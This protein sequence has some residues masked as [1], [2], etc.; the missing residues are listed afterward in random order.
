MVIGKQ[1]RVSGQQQG[2]FGIKRM[3]EDAML[4]EALVSSSLHILVLEDHFNKS[5]ICFFF[6]GLPYFFESLL[7]FEAIVHRKKFTGFHTLP[8]PQIRQRGQLTLVYKH[9][10]Q[11][12][13][14]IFDLFAK[15]IE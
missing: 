12:L 5:Q 4:E 2:A 3:L 6:S 1:I 7:G 9:N 15:N 11:L 13:Q 10:M 14:E 8:C